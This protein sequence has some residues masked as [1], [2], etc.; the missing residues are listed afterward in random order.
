MHIHIL[1]ICG[2]FMGGLALLARELGHRVSGSDQNVYPPMSTQLADAG[3]DLI[4]GYEND[5]LQPQ[6]D[7]V[8]I[9]NALSRGN[10]AVER[11]L[12]QN[13]P[14]VSGAEWLAREV[15]QSRWVVAIAG[16]H[17]KTTTTSLAT[18]ILEYAG[19]KPG[20]LIGG[21]P[22]N[23]GQSARLG[24]APFFVIEADEYDTAFFDKRAKFVHYRPRTAV[25][26]NLE[27]DHADIYPNLAAIE[28]QFHHLLRTVPGNGLVIYPSTDE[29]LQRVIKRGCWSATE[30]LDQ[31]HG[32]WLQNE[33]ADGRAFSIWHQ[34][35]K[36]GEV[37]WSLLGQHNQ[38]NA[39]A[40][41]LAARHCGVSIDVGCAALAEFKGIKRRME[42]KGEVGD[43]AVYDDFAH[44]PTAIATTVSGLRAA[45]GNARIL[46]VVDPRSA[47]MKM[48]VHRDTLADSLRQA[49]MV[50]LHQPAEQQWQARLPTD[51]TIP[52]RNFSD[53]DSIVAAVKAVAK[54]GDQVLVMSNGGFGGIHQKLLDAFAH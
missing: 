3:I 45:I 28:T 33:S 39:L 1:G 12:N 22:G 51:F 6:P 47:T 48:G 54:P 42:L 8:I 17:G 52:W 9:G 21:V 34:N 32:W 37:R 13:L 44:H 10:P 40:A 5:T 23:F 19:L 15:L 20:F 25:L 31:T 43:I 16:T 46:A 7:L 50:F 27:F 38:A 35:Q 53:V 49:D 11:V 41:L 36:Q 2:T 30:T 29:A 18:W 24:E 4:A 14:Y 26:N